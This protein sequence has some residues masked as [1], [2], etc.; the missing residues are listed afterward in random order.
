MMVKM[1][2]KKRRG[3]GGYG[4]GGKKAGRGERSREMGDGVRG[5]TEEKD[6]V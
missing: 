4:E 6:K 3:G 1:M 5:G 2:K